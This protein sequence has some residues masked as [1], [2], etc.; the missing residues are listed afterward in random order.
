VD[1][2]PAKIR[3]SSICIE[4]SVLESL[5]KQNVLDFKEKNKIV[6]LAEKKGV[7]TILDENGELPEIPSEYL[8]ILKKIVVKMKGFLH[9]K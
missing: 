5:D 1:A 3:K 9:S 4:N 7:A 8:F 6:K 2:S